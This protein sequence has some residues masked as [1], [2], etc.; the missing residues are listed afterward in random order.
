MPRKG[1]Q[2][3]QE[4]GKKASIRK[5][6]LPE[7][8]EQVP[9]LQV[10]FL[11]E[12]R[13]MSK[14]ERRRLIREAKQRRG[15]KFKRRIERLSETKDKLVSYGSLQFTEFLAPPST[16]D[17]S[18]K[19]CKADSKKRGKPEFAQLGLLGNSFALST[20]NLLQPFPFLNGGT[21]HR[22]EIRKMTHMNNAPINSYLPLTI[23]IILPVPK[24]SHCPS[25]LPVPLY[26]LHPF[27]YSN[28]IAPQPFT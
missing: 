18:S 12:N 6:E 1:V 19:N 10:S 13:C 20:C 25:P 3:L 9:M 8:H 11:S 26:N 21:K 5:L 17:V 23:P 14:E 4:R 22:D 27:Y 16:L 15:M 24:P 2:I 28:P 7:M